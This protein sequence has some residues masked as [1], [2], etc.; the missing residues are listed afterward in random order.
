MYCT[1]SKAF[2]PLNKFKKRIYD[3]IKK[4]LIY[5]NYSKVNFI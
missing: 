3:K 5:S 4:N 2:I 1:N